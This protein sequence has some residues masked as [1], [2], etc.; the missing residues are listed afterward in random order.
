MRSL[1]VFVVL[2]V[3][4]FAA[5]ASAGT[6]NLSGTIAQPGLACSSTSCS[7]TSGTK[8]FPLPQGETYDSFYSWILGV[9]GTA[10]PTPH[11]RH[12]TPRHSRGFYVRNAFVVAVVTAY[13]NF[14][15]KATNQRRPHH[16]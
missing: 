14:F 5:A 6:C 12:H 4:L 15:N 9:I 8:P 11:P 13:I 1:P 2:M 7:I 3:A 16:S 10:P